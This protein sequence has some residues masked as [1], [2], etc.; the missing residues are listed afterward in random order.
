MKKDLIILLIFLSGI[1]VFLALAFGFG[2]NDFAQ[3]SW[4]DKESGDGPYTIPGGVRNSGNNSL[5]ADQIIDSYDPNKLDIRQT[6]S[7]HKINFS[8][9]NTEINEILYDKPKASPA[10][11][12]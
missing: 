8:T 12:Y 9:H 7:S 4:I 6:T 10:I 3:T 5:D 1:G 2:K 11:K